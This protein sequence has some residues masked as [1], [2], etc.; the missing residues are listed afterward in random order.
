MNV[1][2]REFLNYSMTISWENGEVK[3]IRDRFKERKKL[4][5]QPV[6]IQRDHA[7]AMD[8]T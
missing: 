8:L 7:K 5:A 3:Y 4:S 6:P 1:S 2:I